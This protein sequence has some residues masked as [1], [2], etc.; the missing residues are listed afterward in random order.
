MALSSYR[1]SSFQ[2][3]KMLLRSAKTLPSTQAQDFLI[4]RTREEFRRHQ[5]I[6]DPVR[7]EQL[8]IRAHTSLLSTVP[9]E[10][11]NKEDDDG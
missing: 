6:T 11:L 8:L 1:V 4:D 9:P 10:I 7:I 2:L 3:Y 5:H